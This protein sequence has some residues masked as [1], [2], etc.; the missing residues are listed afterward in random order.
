[1]NIKELADNMTIPTDIPRGDMPGD[2]VNIAEA[3]IKNARG[4]FPL[5]YEMITDR[6]KSNPF[7]RV[8]V[9]VYGGSGSGKSG[10]ASILAYML[11]QAGLSSRTISGDNYPNRIPSD[12]DNERLHIYRVAGIKALRDSGR[13]DQKAADELSAL[14]KENTDSDHSLCL[15]YSWLDSYIDG[16]A[17]ALGDYL[18]SPAEIDYDDINGI[19]S[20]FKNGDDSLWLKRM[21]RDKASI[22]Y[23]ETDVRDI[24]VLILE[25]TH[26]N[27]EHL[28][29]VD[30]PVLLNST[31]EET[32]KYRLSRGRDG[33]IDSPFTT[34]T[35]RLEQELLDSQADKA[36][37]IMSKNGRLLSHEEMHE[38]LSR[39]SA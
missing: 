5:L 22:K 19:L 2:K 14:M 26:G 9:S 6:A 21:G 1:M 38:L 7:G 39:K 10:M 18:G 30:I 31:P 32:L 23:E 37:I 36:A 29:H 3:Q 11:N 8:V 17:R 34:L 35:L 28:K 12:N 15:K 13:L 27:N 25:W 24:K 16:G 33:Q 4:L 20:S